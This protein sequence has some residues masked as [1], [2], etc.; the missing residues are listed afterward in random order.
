MNAID[1]QKLAE[2][3]SNTLERARLDGIIALKTGA[4]AEYERALRR[5]GEAS[6]LLGQQLSAEDEAGAPVCEAREPGESP[7]EIVSRIVNGRRIDNGFDAGLSRKIRCADGYT[8]SVQANRLAYCSPRVDGAEVYTAFELGFPSA[9]DDLLNEYA[10]DG[11]DPTGTVYG[12]VP[13][14]VVL[15]LLTKHGGVA[16]DA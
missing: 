14:E 4:L 16:E 5:I 13:A 10:E 11:T 3:L 1:R 8:V 6:N 7:A 2:R 9:A 12:Y 15:E